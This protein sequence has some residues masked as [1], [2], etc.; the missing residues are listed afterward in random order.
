MKTNEILASLPKWANAT[1]EEIVVSPAWSMPCRIGEKQCVMRLDAP[2]PTD[3][4]DLEIKLEDESFVLSLVDTNLFE[5]LHRLWASRAEVPAPILLALVEKECSPLLQ[6]VENFSH[7]QLKV[8]GLVSA[9]KV[10]ADRLC[11]RICDG[12]EE[13]FAFSITAKPSIVRTLGRISFIDVED[14]SVRDVSLPC[15]SE[16]AAFVLSA[17]DRASLSVGDALLLP[18]FGTVAPRLIV[19]GRFV[20]NENGVFAFRDDGMMLVLDSNQRTI[21]LGELLD[22]ANSPSAPSVPTPSQ[23]RLVSA[24]KPVA[25]GH[26][27]SL[28]GQNA[29]IVESLATV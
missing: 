24:G 16:F 4:L 21:T 20:V 3:T 22:F 8:A 27:D 29:L 11:A 5:D 15:V 18:E 19:D 28:S 14:S 12:D 10:P 25:F 26:L 13:I 23:L 1:S 6:L 9:D 7:R 2:R 17:A